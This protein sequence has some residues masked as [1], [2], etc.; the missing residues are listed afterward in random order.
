[1]TSIQITSY[2]YLPTQ[3]VLKRLQNC[4]IVRR[5]PSSLMQ[6]ILLSLLENPKTLEFHRVC[7][8]IYTQPLPPDIVLN[9]AKKSLKWLFFRRSFTKCLPQKHVIPDN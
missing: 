1:M 8:F 4:Q 2:P 5:G 3:I 6:F 9:F 7:H